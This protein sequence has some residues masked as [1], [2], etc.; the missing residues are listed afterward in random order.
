MEEIEMVAMLTELNDIEVYF[1]RLYFR[2][3]SA[4]NGLAMI[5]NAAYKMGARMH[6]LPKGERL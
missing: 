4:E 3:S 6:K 1:R 2:E 5:A